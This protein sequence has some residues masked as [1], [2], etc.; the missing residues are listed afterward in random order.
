MWESS[1]QSPDFKSLQLLDSV[2]AVIII[3]IIIIIVIIIQ[4]NTSFSS[5]D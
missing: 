3:I 4:L 2:C 1:I 5:F